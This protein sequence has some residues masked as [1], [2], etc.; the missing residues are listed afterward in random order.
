MKCW[1]TCSNRSIYF[2]STIIINKLK[3]RVCWGYSQHLTGQCNVVQAA[4]YS[5]YR[6]PVIA[7]AVN[8]KRNIML[9]CFL[10]LINFVC[11][12]Y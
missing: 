11:V 12:Q 6:K 3:A 10:V 1:F 2:D 7:A 4:I 5:F 9:S 8:M